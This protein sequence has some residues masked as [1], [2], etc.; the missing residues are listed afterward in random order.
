MVRQKR[1]TVGSLTST[2]SARLAAV[3]NGSLDN[4]DSIKLARIRSAFEAVAK[5]AFSRSRTDVLNPEVPL[6]TS[7]VSFIS[8]VNV[9][10]F[11]CRI[12]THVLVPVADQLLGGGDFPQRSGPGGNLSNRPRT[13]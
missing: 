10:H 12:L 9:L 7:Y 6:G 5:L 2:F 4:S 1:P 8:F 13:A 11:Y 3:S